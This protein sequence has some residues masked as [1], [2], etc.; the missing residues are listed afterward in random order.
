MLL[1]P[2]FSPLFDIILVTIEKAPDMIGDAG[3]VQPDMA[4]EKPYHGTILRTGP[5]VK[6][7]KAGDRI[8][9]T[10]YSGKPIVVDNVKFQYMKEAEVV[11][12]L[13]DDASVT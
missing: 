11:G 12:V 5:D 1:K 9:F 8:V 2:K 4:K 6:Y 7:L 10:K 3:L 13:E